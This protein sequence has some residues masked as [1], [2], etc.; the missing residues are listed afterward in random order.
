MLIVI[1]GLRRAAPGFHFRARLPP[2][3]TIFMSKKWQVFL[4]LITT[5]IF[6]EVCMLNH[7]QRVKPSIPRMETPIAS[8][9]ALPD[10]FNPNISGAETNE[11]RP[12][13]LDK[14]LVTMDHQNVPEPAVDPEIEKERIQEEKLRTF[15]DWARQQTEKAFEW[16]LRQPDGPQRREVLVDVCYQVAQSDPA[17]AVSMAQQL[18]L[19]QGQ[20]AVMENLIQQWAGQDLI[21]A[22]SWA[23]EQLPS[24]EKD[25]LMM[26]IAFV[27]SQTDPA[28]AAQLVSEQIAPGQTQTEATMTV[29]HQWAL[30]DMQGAVAW[31]QLFPAGTLRERAMNELN[32][33][34]QASTAE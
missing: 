23:Q 29:L 31:A 28:D 4:V 5:M 2:D 32:G 7:F 26:R 17:M 22:Y 25:E 15:R 1:N 13:K 24:E 20:G 18:C 12:S 11:E 21:A 9:D 8:V 10:E 6:A 16:A 34:T 27:Y 30:Q 14:T 33:M 3:P 19:D